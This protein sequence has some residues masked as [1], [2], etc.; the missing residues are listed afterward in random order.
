[1][2]TMQDLKGVSFRSGEDLARQGAAKNL[3]TIIKQQPGYRAG[4][5]EMMV[6]ET[7][8]GGLRLYVRVTGRWMDA[9]LDDL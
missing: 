3:V 7:I 1:M 9:S 2:K 5:A 6:C 4:A 8:M